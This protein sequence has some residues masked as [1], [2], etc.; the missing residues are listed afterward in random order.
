MSNM[1]NALELSGVS[2][3]APPQFHGIGKDQMWP[4]ES[5]FLQV[6]RVHLMPTEFD[7]HHPRERD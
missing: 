2:R 5:K 7:N 1:S 4:Q 6:L 3:P